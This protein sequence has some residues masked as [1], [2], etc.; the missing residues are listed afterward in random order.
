MSPQDAHR[1][2]PQEALQAYLEDLLFEA[3]APAQQP[4]PD[5]AAERARPEPAVASAP[6]SRP[7]PASTPVTAPQAEA[8]PAH[9]QPMAH[10][11][12]VLEPRP[13]RWWRWST[14]RSRSPYPWPWM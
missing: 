1:I 12:Q 4:R 9:P 14:S 11:P 6:V 7:E 13:L 2:G 3:P 8:A 10:Q 5:E